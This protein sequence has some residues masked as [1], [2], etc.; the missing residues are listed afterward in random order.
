MVQTHLYKSVQLSQYI[1]LQTVSLALTL[2]YHL[3]EDDMCDF[4]WYI[5]CSGF[6]GLMVYGCTFYYDS[7]MRMHL[8]GKTLTCPVN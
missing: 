5:A 1:Y 7:R 6:A 8:N 4:D 3:R 2:T